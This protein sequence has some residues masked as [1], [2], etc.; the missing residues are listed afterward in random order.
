MP[1][2]CPVCN[3]NNPPGSAYCENCGA[4]LSGTAARVEPVRG[5]G[6][7]RDLRRDPAEDAGHRSDAASNTERYD[8]QVPAPADPIEHRPPAVT[9]AGPDYRPTPFEDAGP[10]SGLEEAHCPR[11]GEFRTYNDTVCRNCGLPFQERTVDGVPMAVVVKGPPAGFWIRFIAALIDGA[12][13]IAI[14]SILWPLLFSESYWVERTATFEDGGTATTFS[15][16]PWHV[17][18][19]FSYSTFFLA[20]WG[21]TPGK[22]LLGIRIYDRNGNPRLGLF[23]AALRTV[24]TALSA[25][26]LLI[27]YIMAG[28]RRDKRA[29]HDLIADTYPTMRR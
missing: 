15:V 6:D 21:A 23:R 13:V 26:L 25:L 18:I 1:A 27:G 7:L 8:Y 14:G 24:S 10:E 9:P 29:L 22:R 19:S 12:V 16:Q 28:F 5:A 11:C 3:G 4:L 17:L 20:F 2:Q